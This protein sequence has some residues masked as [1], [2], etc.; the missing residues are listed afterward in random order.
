MR[1]HRRLTGALDLYG[2]LGKFGM[3]YLGSL[4][5]SQFI[6]KTIS[7]AQL[8]ERLA[9]AINGIPKGT[10][11]FK[12]YIEGWKIRRNSKGSYYYASLY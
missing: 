8:E 6:S 5:V 2:I 7:L 11:E 10:I 1:E 4:F 3:K 9:Y 12:E